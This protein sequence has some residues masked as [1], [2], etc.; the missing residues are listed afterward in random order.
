M[1]Q[2]TDPAIAANVLNIAQH[3]NIH[4]GELPADATALLALASEI[5]SAAEAARDS[6]IQVPAVLEVLSAALA[7]TAQEPVA[8]TPPNPFAP[9]APAAPAAPVAAP[10]P[11]VAPAA[12]DIDALI[13]G[14]D[15]L[16]VG[17]IL[18]ALDSLAPEQVAAVKEYEAADGGRVKIMNYAPDAVP[19][20]APPAAPEPAVAAPPVAAP[21][22]APEPASP[23][24][25]PEF[26]ANISPEQYA[27]VEP[28][29]G[30]KKAKIGEIE[31]II[32]GAFDTHPDVQSLFA[33][34]WEYEN[35]T[36]KPRSRLLKKLQDIAANG[37]SGGS[38]SPAA[39]AAPAAA[40]PVVAPEPADVQPEPPFASAGQPTASQLAAPLATSEIPAHNQGG[41]MQTG[42][43]TDQIVANVAKPFDGATQKATAY[44]IEQGFP[45]IPA[46]ADIPAI[47]ADFTELS[48]AQVRSY[49]SLFNAVQARLIYLHAQAEGHAEDAK[50]VLSGL[51]DQYIRSGHEDWSAKTT[52]G[53]KE[54]FANSQADVIVAKHA[55]HEWSEVARQLKAQISIYDLTCRRLSREQTGREAEQATAVA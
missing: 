38:T 46:V 7:G 28:W 15:D 44:V 14:Y 21:L 6:G 5:A 31:A 42:I 25:G 40:T 10:D 16:K 47:P 30:Y 24:P 36:A 29:P 20:A 34:V 1:A 53:E 43:S 18:D 51:V 41:A 4:K 55:R 26:P 2:I 9:A 35:A 22:A 52:L 11:V 33:H 19:A 45:V 12:F 37:V 39:P 17:E 3:H 23:A 50:V 48:D 49:A 8:A 54:A 27:S 32:T 13:P